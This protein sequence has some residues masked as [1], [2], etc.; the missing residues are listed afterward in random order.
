VPLNPFAKSRIDYP[1]LPFLLCLFFNSN[2]APVSN[3]TMTPRSVQEFLS[4]YA[5]Q[6]PDS[7]LQP[8][9]VVEICR[10][11]SQQGWLSEVSAGGMQG[12]G[13]RYLCSIR[14]N[15][16]DLDRP[17][18]SRLLTCGVY[19]F[20]AVYDFYAGSVLPI[21][22]WGRSGDP[23]IG[24]CFV[25]NPRWAL[26]A[27][28]CVTPASAFALKG[29][30]LSELQRAQFYTHP[31]EAMDLALILF[32]AAVFSQPPIPIPE[33]DAEILDEVM[34]LGF[35]NVPGFEPTLAAEAAN[36]AGRLTAT[37]GRV[38][39]KPM[40]IFARSELFLVTARVRGG[41]SGG[42]VLDP[43][44]QAVGIVSREPAADAN[45]GEGQQYDELGYGTAIPSSCAV[46]LLTGVVSGAIPALNMS[47]VK[48]RE[49]S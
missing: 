49:F 41:F 40:E 29:V 21:V 45:P 14:G 25:G 3:G 26:T 28:H 47:G 17:S 16:A 6:R 12:L 20:P 31:N 33:T 19:G 10:K 38:A 8:F 36:I 18:V 11:M 4:E 42:P 9:V 24:T 43:S 23:Q 5:V 48:F 46:E 32:D 27:S 7:G 35:P 37:R 34:A 2:Q 22:N 44:G 39:S 15:P 13:N 1:N 30:S